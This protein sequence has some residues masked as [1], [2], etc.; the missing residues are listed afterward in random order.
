ML[1]IH[2][3]ATVAVGRANDLNGLMIALQSALVTATGKPPE[4][5]AIS[6]GTCEHMTAP[7]GAMMSIEFLSGP[8]TEEANE[9]TKIAATSLAGMLS[10]DLAQRSVVA[11]PAI[12]GTMPPV[13]I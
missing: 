13:T 4:E 9:I 2:L 10:V 8:T 11:Y 6:G 7:Y 5:I 3:T 1:L 12:R